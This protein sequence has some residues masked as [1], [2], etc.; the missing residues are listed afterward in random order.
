M[1]Q[2]I[3]TKKDIENAR[4]ITHKFD[5]QKSWEKFPCLTNYLGIIGEQ[6]MKDYLSNLHVN[7]TW[8]T[9]V[10]NDYTQADFIVNGKS[11]DVKTTFNLALYLQ[12]PK[13]DYY[14]LCVMETDEKT[15]SIVGW[16]DKQTLIK[17]CKR[18]KYLVKREGR[19][20]F[21]IPC[22]LLKTMSEFEQEIK[23]NI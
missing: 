23:R 21:A 2:F 3:V 1:P 15:L 22:E 11:L 5:S 17:L 18:K 14:V 6:K 20:D 7:F 10:K 8:N 19:Q 4:E 12:D 9:F 13:F 16:L